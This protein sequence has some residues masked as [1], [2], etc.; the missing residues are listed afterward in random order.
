[1]PPSSSEH[2]SPGESPLHSGVY[3][4]STQGSHARQRS[5]G[6]RGLGGGGPQ[7]QGYAA[8]G[9][10]TQH[11]AALLDNPLEPSSPTT[12]YLAHERPASNTPSFSSLRSKYGLLEDATLLS[13]PYTFEKEADDGLHDPRSLQGT[14]KGRSRYIYERGSKGAVSCLGVLNV[15][16][17]LALFLGIAGLFAGWPI[18]QW[19]SDYFSHYNTSVSFYNDGAAYVGAPNIT[20]RTGPIDPDTPESAYTKLSNDGTTMLQLVF[21]DE[22]NTDGRIFDPGMDPFWEAVDFHYWQTEDLEW[23]DPGSAGTQDGYL[24]LELTEEDNSTSHDLGYFGG[25][26]QGRVPWNKF[27]YTGGMI[28]ASISL[29]GSGTSQGYWPALWMMG[30]LGRAGYGAN[31]DGMWPY[32]YDFCDVGTLPNQTD[33]TTGEPTAAL[34]EGDGEHDDNLSWLTGQKLSRCTCPDDDHPGPVDT[35]GEFFGRSAVRL[36]PPLTARPLPSLTSLPAQPEYDVFEALVYL[37]YANISQTAQMAPFNLNYKLSNQSALELY[38][39]EFGTRLNTYVGGALQQSASGISLTDTSTYNQTDTSK[40]AQ[41]GLEY[42]PTHWGGY[43]TGEMT[44]MQQDQ[45]MWWLSDAAM[46][47]DEG[48]MISNRSISGEPL[49]IITNLGMSNGFTEVELDTLTFPARMRI[50]YIRVYQ[51]PDR[52]N[53]GCSPD[54]Y[55]TADYIESHLGAYK[56]PNYTT[57]EEAGYTK[58]RNRLVDTC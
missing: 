19:A 30:N 39:S 28:D 51:Q 15:A 10:P 11:R 49:Y 55:P 8:L 26:I 23:Y 3:S 14:R 27:C 32:S 54:D 58:P 43:G 42:T 56:N 21:S 5:L 2:V 4:S 13:L 57:W 22:F 44:W 40:F 18:G 48:A 47:A 17:V 35:D 41:Y 45:K 6:Q 46:A 16:A 9:A 24:W 36:F 33:P 12:Q 7:Q 52:I 20:T 38:D 53:I 37:G 1:M 25:M 31:L 50:D 34:T 29:P